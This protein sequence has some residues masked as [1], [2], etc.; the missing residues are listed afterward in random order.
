M[1]FHEPPATYVR[2]IELQTADLER[3]RSFYENILGLQT[4]R[5]EKNELTLSAD[6]KTALIH[7]T[8]PEYIEERPER[9]T[10]LYHFALLVPTRADLGRFIRHLVEL[11]YP[12]QGASDHDVSEAVYLADPDGHGI[13]V[14]RDREAS[15]W[16]INDGLIHMTVDPLD[17]EAV[18]A[19]A[20]G[21]SW[22]GMPLATRMG[23]IHLHV[24]NLAE[25]E[26][27]YCGALGFQLVSRLG[28][29]ALFVSS[30]FYHHHLGLNTWAGKQA[31][32]P[33]ANSIKLNWFDVVYPTADEKNA[34]LSRLRTYG[35]A[36]HEANNEIFI[37]DPS[38]TW[39]KVTTHP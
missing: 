31:S 16:T 10:G 22:S 23:H 14:Y 32:A 4:I 36:I 38:G 37:K 30:A 25:A 19:E 2:E 20:E 5:S 15:A 8:L 11:K 24:H 9:T 26:A 27:F 12:V 17:A 39:L 1:A 35:A 18:I 21:T 13:E 7:L 3:A 34:A 33:P 6:G 29:H 28:E